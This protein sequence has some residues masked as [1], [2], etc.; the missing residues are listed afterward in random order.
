MKVCSNSNF[1]LS[2]DASCSDR[3]VV[4]PC[5]GEPPRSSS[6][7][8]DHVIF[9]SLPVMQRLRPGDREVVLLSGASVSVS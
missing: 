5:S 2:A 8:A 1:T 3:V 6:Q 7:L 9:M 4:E